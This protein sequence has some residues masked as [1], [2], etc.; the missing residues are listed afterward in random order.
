MT[1]TLP[2]PE[3]VQEAT[4]VIAGDEELDSPAASEEQA[5]EQTFQPAPAATAPELAWT[6]E[7]IEVELDDESSMTWDEP[8]VPVEPAAAVTG[9]AAEMP[10]SQDEDA[11]TPL[12]KKEIKAARKK[13][14]R[15][16]KDQLRAAKNP[17]HS[18]D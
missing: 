10:A 17:R 15:D 6:E 8:N 3:A 7:P 18:N 12:T 2:R 13:D 11:A 1:D 9:L 14:K 4:D 16:R 5:P